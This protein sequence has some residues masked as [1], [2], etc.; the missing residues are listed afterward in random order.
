MFVSTDLFYAGTVESEFEYT[1]RSAN[2][3]S[4]FLTAVNSAAAQSTEANSA[5]QATQRSLVARTGA[6]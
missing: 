3:L 6:R 1:M 4:E 5:A 2:D